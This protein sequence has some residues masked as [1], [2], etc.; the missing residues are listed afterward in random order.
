MSKRRRIES[1]ADEPKREAQSTRDFSLF[2]RLPRD[3]ANSAREF[4]EYDPRQQAVSKQWQLDAS[5]RCEARTKKGVACVR[6]GALAA[7]CVRYCLEEA[8]CE[9]WVGRLLTSALSVVHVAI[10]NDRF[11]VRSGD[12]HA[13]VGGRSL[14]FDGERWNMEELDDGFVNL[15]W[16]L[17]AEKQYRTFPWGDHGYVHWSMDTVN[18]V[19]VLC[20]AA[21]GH[22]T[23]ALHLSIGLEVRSDRVERGPV[24]AV[25]LDERGK[26]VQGLGLGQQWRVGLDTGGPAVQSDIE[27][28]DAAAVWCTEVT[29]EGRSCIQGNRVRS[30]CADYCLASCS[31]WLPEWLGELTLVVSCPARVKAPSSGDVWDILPDRLNVDLLD[32][33]GNNL[34]HLRYR[35]GSGSALPPRP[36]SESG[37][38]RRFSLPDPRAVRW[39]FERRRTFCAPCCEIPRSTRCGRTLCTGCR[40]TPR[41][42]RP[43]PWRDWARS[44]ARAWCL[45]TLGTARPVRLRTTGKLRPV[46]RGPTFQFDKWHVKD[47]F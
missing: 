28:R 31:A 13:S 32:A 3:L 17:V 30:R 20:R 4:L 15:P 24:V 19:R 1:Q 10:G 47:K 11:P 14:Q 8:P 5:R 37:C 46:H 33:E 6:D 34:V 21:Q 12:V 27:L 26:R 40:R 16:N 18:A 39:S 7:S 41:G 44:R 38:A 2:R 22:R 45:R 9:E 23:T 29:A 36:G 43:R 25:F 42:D 35:D